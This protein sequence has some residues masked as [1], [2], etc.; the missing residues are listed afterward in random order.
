MHR[1]TAPLVR[2]WW[3]AALTLIATVAFARYATERQPRVYRATAA[4]VAAP[5][6]SEAASFTDVLRTVEVLE[7]RSVL[8]TFAELARSP[9]V[10]RT[11]RSALGWNEE[12]APGY[13]VSATVLPH[14]NVVRISAEG[15]DAAGVAQY[16]QA[17]ADAAGAEA[18]RLYPPFVVEV[19]SEAVEPRGPILPDP[20]RNIVVAGMIG[21]FAGLGLALLYGRFMPQLGR[22]A[23]PL[24][25][26]AHAA[27]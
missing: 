21:L 9:G 23:I 2:G 3:V 27:E 18:S 5:N 16:A 13:S 4:V 20:R 17:I 14:A 26:E 24:R 11:A 12:S 22:S 8:A 25:A 19:L 6:S 15:G 10:N 1:Y 7:R